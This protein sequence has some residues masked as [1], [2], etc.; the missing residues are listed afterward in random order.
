MKNNKNRSNSKIKIKLSSL[1]PPNRTNT[2]QSENVLKS[3][4]TYWL[5][6][7]LTELTTGCALEAKQEDKH[8]KVRDEKKERFGGKKTKEI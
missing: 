6:W 2:T 1:A 8:I 7:T 3:G 4:R 5:R